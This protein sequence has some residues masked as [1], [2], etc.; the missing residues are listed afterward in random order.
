M[1]HQTVPL[2]ETGRGS[3]ARFNKKAIM[4][5][6]MRTKV[7]RR[8][9]SKL[10][11]F[12]FVLFVIL[13]AIDSA[14]GKTDPGFTQHELDWIK[15]HPVIRVVVNDGPAPLTIWGDDQEKKITLE[16]PA[17]SIEPYERSERPPGSGMFQ[18]GNMPPRL[19]RGSNIPLVAV[20]DPAKLNFRGIAADYLEELSKITGIKFVVTHAA[21]GNIYGIDEAM[22]QGLVDLMP[23]RIVDTSQ[24]RPQRPDIFT[25]NPYIRI[26]VIIVTRP[27]VPHI[28]DF[29][30]LRNMKVA[31]TL[32]TGE[33]LRTL[34]LN[35]EVTHANPREGLKD[36]ATGKFDAFICELYNY[37]DEWSRNP[38]TNLKIAGELPPPSEFSLSVGAHVKELIPILNKALSSIPAKNKDIIWK[39][40]LRIEDETKP[41]S[42]PWM[43]TALISVIVLLLASFFAI[44]Y[45]HRR[46]HNIRTAVD[47]LDPHLISISV[48]NNIV[49]TEVTEALCNATGFKFDDLIG[50]PLM[51][52]GGPVAEEN[53][54]MEYIWRTLDKGHA[55]RGEIKFIKKDGSTLWAE[56]IMSPLRRKNDENKGYTIICHDVTQKKHFETLAVR[57]ELTGLFN[58]RHFNNTVPG[59]LERAH[60][61]DLYLALILMDVDN[62]KKYND[63]YG[64]PAGDRVLESM[65]KTLRKIFQ[66]SDD[67]SFRLGGEEF[68]VTVVVSSSDDAVKVAEKILESV[69]ALKIE[70]QDNNPGIVTV[71]IGLAVTDNEK[72][73]DLQSLYKKADTALYMAKENGRNN[74]M[75]L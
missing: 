71:S 68:G 30:V 40:W 64:H 62:F 7:S 56:A 27:D 36:V 32:P 65:G 39:K 59:L 28:E 23:T 42:S 67:M 58:R 22:S 53:G 72:T 49:I 38:V 8:F 66:R 25:T 4:D 3:P 44:R 43:K 45:F 29:E 33:K 2:L 35:I 41:V 9:R 1:K 74:C 11:R 48:D 19:M 47:A 26:P 73:P 69:R 50:K 70:H 57:D 18:P 17:A 37:S 21:Q 24:G 51:A 55:W 10:Y 31:G 12:L 15:S 6:V 75:F 13:S 46:F 60:K 14:F 63:N 5:F 34:G 16:D 20:K 54:S 61:E 52:L